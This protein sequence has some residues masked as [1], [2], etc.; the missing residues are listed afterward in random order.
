MHYQKNFLTSVIFRLDFP[1]IPALKKEDDIQFTKDIADKYPEYSKQ[2]V[3][4]TSL[5][6]TS[7]S[8]S[9]QK[10]KYW[11]RDYLSDKNGN[12]GVYLLPQALI[13]EHKQKQYKNFAEFY[14]DVEYIYKI[15]QTN[16]NISNYSKIGLRYINEIM[17]PGINPLDWHDY[18]R[19]E[20]AS[21]INTNQ[22][23]KSKLIRSMHQLHFMQDEIS[24][25][26]NY[27][28]FNK[29][30]PNSITSPEF[31]L[32]YDSFEAGEIASD[33]VLNQLKNLNKIASE[34]FNDDITDKLKKIMGV[35]NE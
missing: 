32:D 1:E 3:S 15:L 30:Y 28:I 34:L 35:T 21:A 16:Y 8:D 11:R 33:E 31:I 9:Y 24:T 6:F 25:V 14:K 17:V 22:N 26:F 23:N 7:E 4:I 19:S 29:N 12:K 27:G 5:E 18:I 13:I 10:V 2:Q 20:L